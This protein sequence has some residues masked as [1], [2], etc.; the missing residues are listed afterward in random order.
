MPTSY[1]GGTQR[2]DHAQMPALVIRGQGKRKAEIPAGQRER[3]NTRAGLPKQDDMCITLY[4]NT[5]R[6]MSSRNA[7]RDLC[8]WVECEVKVLR[9]L[10]MHRFLVA[11]APSE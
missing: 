9:W 8:G 4:S 6:T 11:G 2:S 5:G 3:T 7:V 1:R 10:R